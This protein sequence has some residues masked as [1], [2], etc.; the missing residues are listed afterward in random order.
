VALL[1]RLKAFRR[2]PLGAE[3]LA[4]LAAGIPHA[5][6][7]VLNSVFHATAGPFEDAIDAGLGNKDDSVRLAAVEAGLSR[8]VSAARAAAIRLARPGEASAGPYLKFVAMF[9]TGEEH[10]IVYS[11]LRIPA[12][13][14]D[15]IWALGHL[16]TARAAEACLAGMRHEPLARA[17][18]EA[19]CWI[20]G[21]NLVRDKLEKLEPSEESPV[22]EDDDLDANLVPAAD[23][24]WPLPDVDAT[25]EHWNARRA[26]L[27]PD[28]RYAHGTP[29]TPAALMALVETGPMLRRHDLV[30][31]LRSRTRGA[32]D[33]ETRAFAARQRQMMQAARAAAAT[34]GE[35]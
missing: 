14:R 2:A 9:G 22:L 29:V 35:R 25:R 7:H 13:Q 30:L 6:A 11:A 5:H 17:C 20:T 28:V 19:Y 3:T 1:C 24:L 34:H 27:A 21:A 18:A 32:Y 23:D 15:A 31:E 16:G 10:D 8:G 26:E 12:L 4:A 33:V